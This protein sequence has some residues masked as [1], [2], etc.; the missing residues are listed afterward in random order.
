MDRAFATPRVAIIGGGLAGACAAWA[1]ARRGASITLFERDTLASGASGAAVG[2]LQPFTGMRLRLREENIRGFFRTRA[3]LQDLLVE[4]RT[5]RETG[6]LRVVLKEDQAERWKSSYDDS[7]AAHVPPDF[8][9]WLEGSS[10][11]ALEPRLADGVC[12]GVLIPQG[13]FV[14]I[15]AFV[16]ALVDVSGATVAEHTAVH[17][18]ESKGNGLLVEY[19][20]DRLQGQF[21]GVV[22]ASGA[23]APEPLHD[24]SLVLAP[25]MGILAAFGG[26]APPRIAINH[27]GYIAAWR[28]ESLLV[29]T[30]DRRDGFE[31]EPT[32]ATIQELRTRLSDVLDVDEEPRLLRVWKGLRPAMHD[33][34]PVVK[35]ATALPN[36]WI[37][38][39]FGG[40]GLLLGPSLAEELAVAIFG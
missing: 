29:G 25:Y 38:T 40:R 30:V 10:L 15:P 27:R 14:D 20:E 7:L 36:T 34:T 13:A 28:D 5:W 37:F 32:E 35:A 19:G 23:Q 24:E 21:D 18:V 2:A 8:I 31:H 39:G 3:L 33:H 26:V 12:A 6:V 22:V 16:R 17:R 4:G 1:L 11:R 9:Q